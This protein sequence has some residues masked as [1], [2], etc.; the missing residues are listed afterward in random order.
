MEK[1]TIFSFR[2]LGFLFT[3]LSV[4]FIVSVTSCDMK[5]PKNSKWAQSVKGKEHFA[6][7]C[8]SCHGLDGR[9]V[10]V[11]SL[12]KRPADLTQIRASTS[13]NEFPIMYVASTIDG[14]KM[15]KSHGTRDM[16]V[17]GE[18][19]SKEEQ[20]TEDEIKGKLAELIAYLMSIQS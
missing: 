19:F 5:P 11:D 18:V 9:G 17:W 7:Y 2:N 4:F 15:A 10:K 13:N 16:P 20:L 12:S 1:S 14:R 3:F 6:K 8:S